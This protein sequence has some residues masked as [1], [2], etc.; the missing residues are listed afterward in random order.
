MEKHR[1][2]NEIALERYKIIAPILAAMEENADK[3]KIGALKSEACG[4]AGVSR[5]TLARWLYRYAQ[6]GLDGL[7]YRPGGDSKKLIPGELVKEAISL[8]REVP[9]RSVPQ[10]IEILE[11]EGKA[12][13]GFLRRSTLQDRLNEAGYSTAQMKLYQQPGIA[14]RR[15]QRLERNDMWQADIKH[16]GYIKSKELFF[17]GFIDDAT[18]YVVHG[19]FYHEFDQSIVED[20]LRKAILK[21]GL[22]GRL[23][24]DNGRQFRNKWMERACAILNI[25]L[26]FT[27]PY[28]PEA[29]G[30]IERF[31]RT[32]DSFLNEAA[33]KNPQELSEM[34]ALLNIWLAECYH[35]KEHSGIDAAPEVAFASSKKPLR[36][37]PADTIARAFLRAEKRKVDKIGCIS[38]KGRKY[39]V[40]AVYA[41][42]TI[43]VVYDPADISILTVEDERFN[44]S[45]RIYEL[46]I[47][48]HTGPRPKL[49]EHMTENVPETSR[50]LDAKEKIHQNRK[51]NVRRAISFKAI[52]AELGG[53]SDV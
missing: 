6:E 44:T 34:N 24:F 32:L 4:F 45:F 33:L 38:F 49:P 27:A 51:E 42:R 30:K 10:I 8:R 36:F 23:Y 20:S 21:H 13:K 2:G 48:T 22:P 47:G 11:M 18:R 28:A 29:K 5:K 7:K 35:N 41:G 43:D 14:A 40:G 25:K 12:P 39:E 17:V 26:I 1:T 31:N 3:G 50:L 19:E 53:D 52:N 16:C 37:L 9:S 15:F 46:V